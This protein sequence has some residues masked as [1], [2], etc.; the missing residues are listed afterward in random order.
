MTFM[1]GDGKG[2]H[3]LIVLIKIVSGDPII[4]KMNGDLLF[5]VINIGNPADVPVE[6][7]F[8]PLVAFG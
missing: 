1:H 2:M 3:E 4:G 5:R 7:A 8:S 6:D